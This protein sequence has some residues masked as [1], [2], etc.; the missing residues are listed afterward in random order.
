MWNSFLIDSE[1]GSIASLNVVCFYGGYFCAEMPQQ[2][3]ICI[4]NELQL[5]LIKVMA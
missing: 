2:G 3:V 1:A 4:E 5:L